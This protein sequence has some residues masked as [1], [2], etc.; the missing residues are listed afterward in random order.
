MLARPALLN[1]SIFKPDGAVLPLKEVSHPVLRPLCTRKVCVCCRPDAAPH[2]TALHLARDVEH[3]HEPRLDGALP[4]MRSNSVLTRGRCSLQ[5]A[6]TTNEAIVVRFL[7][8]NASACE[9]KG[10]TKP[11]SISC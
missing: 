8:R 6:A 10:K 11:A 4:L 3:H 7:F 2:P 5:T 9:K 1:C